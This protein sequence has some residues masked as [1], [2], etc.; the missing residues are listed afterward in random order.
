MEIKDLMRRKINRDLQSFLIVS[1]AAL[2][3][4]SD[5]SEDEPTED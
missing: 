2:G 3:A 5:Q 4:M 1:E